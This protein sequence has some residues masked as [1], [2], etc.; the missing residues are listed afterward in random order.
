MPTMPG[1]LR[2]ESFLLANLTFLP[3]AQ[4]KTF[5]LSLLVALAGK[6]RM[7]FFNWGTEKLCCEKVDRG[8]EHVL[9]RTVKLPVI[10]GCEV[11]WT[12]YC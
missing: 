3:V 7:S 4:H 5:V 11:D 12:V 1:D 6:T 9:G 8:R 10:A 2:V